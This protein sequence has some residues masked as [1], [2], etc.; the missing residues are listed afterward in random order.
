MDVVARAVAANFAERLG[1]PATVENR[2]GATGT[3]GTGAVAKADPDGYTLLVTSNNIVVAPHL[4]KSVPYNPMTDFEPIT[5][6]SYSA[7][8]LAVSN[9]SGFETVAELLAYAKA[10]PGKLNYSS[11][12]IGTTQHISME[13]LKNVTGVNI[14]HVPYRGSSGALTDLISGQI[15][16]AFVPVDLAAPQFRAG[17]LKVLAVGSP[18]R[19]KMLPEVPTLQESGVPGIESNPWHAFAAPKGTP[20]PI[21][22]KLN[23]EIRAILDLPDVRSSLESYGLQISTG[24]PEEMRALM[25]RDTVSF[26]EIIRRNKI[27][28][29]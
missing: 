3:I 10:N 25:Q 11:P 21:I 4:L 29:D 24:T 19:H 9:K 18:S 12:G 23:K 17:N 13:A 1:E 14:V 15:S 6:T 7:M 2:P 8:M 20:R 5:V 26:G 28:I 16:V 27:S 22:D